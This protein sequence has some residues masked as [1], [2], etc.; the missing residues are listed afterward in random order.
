D[1]SGVTVTLTVDATAQHL[2]RGH[3]G[4]TVAFT[5][6][7]RSAM[8]TVGVPEPAPVGTVKGP[9]T[10]PRRQAL[11]TCPRHP[12]GRE[13]RPYHDPC[14]PLRIEGTFSIAAEAT[15][16]MKKGTGSSPLS[17]RACSSTLRISARNKSS[18]LTN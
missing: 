1:V 5:N 2:G 18:A 10:S 11:R 7:T 3:Y 14:R 9:P 8:L 13:P 12:R 4:P 17:L 15:C 6:T 16:G